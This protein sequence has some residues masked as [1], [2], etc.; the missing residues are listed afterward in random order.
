MSSFQH[1]ARFLAVPLSLFL[2]IRWGYTEPQGRSPEGQ[3]SRQNVPPTS[4]PT[5][6]TPTPTATPTPTPTP[7]CQFVQANLNMLGFSHTGSVANPVSTP[8]VPSTCANKFITDL[9]TCVG[10]RPNDG[11]RDDWYAV[12]FANLYLL[13]RNSKLGPLNNGGYCTRLTVTP[14][15]PNWIDPQTR[16][17]SYWH[18][19]TGDVWGRYCLNGYLMARKE[20]EPTTGSCFTNAPVTSDQICGSFD[21]SFIKSSPI[22][23][24]WHSDAQIDDQISV[25]QFPL[26]PSQPNDYVGWRASEKAPLLVYDPEHRGVITEARQ[27]FGNWTFG[28]KQ[29]ARVGAH[30]RSDAKSAL[31]TEWAHGFEALAT[32]DADG[33]GKVDR[34]ELDPLALWFDRDRDAVSDEGEVISVHDVGVIALYYNARFPQEGRHVHLSLGYDRIIDGKVLSGASVDWYG[35]QSSS[36]FG[37]LGHHLMNGE[38]KSMSAPKSPASES[39]EPTPLRE[40]KLSE[41]NPFAGLWEVTFDS[42]SISNSSTPAMLIL[43]GGEALIEGYSVV[44]LPFARTQL[45]ELEGATTFFFVKGERSINDGEHTAVFRSDFGRARTN[46]TA[47]LSADGS[48]LLGTTEATYEVAG[49]PRRISYEWK[50]RKVSP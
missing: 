29:L 31:Q 18:H 36:K 42:G 23:L 47:R 32:L 46:T 8:T 24:L 33:N 15:D 9:N 25:V 20:P 10:N 43:G 3:N 1:L 28:G 30:A 44:R 49:K 38:W 17:D 14:N 19:I 50:G 6:T 13:G 27:L 40:Q 7:P 21:V 5:P 2:L 34:S 35:E 16:A 22:S 39:L 37:L 11:Y 4:T 48:T 26:N 45:T 41:R 12:C